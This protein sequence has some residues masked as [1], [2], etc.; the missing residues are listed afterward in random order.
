MKNDPEPAGSPERAGDL[1]KPVARKTACNRP[2]CY[3]LF[4]PRSSQQKYC[5]PE[6]AQAMETVLAREKRYRDQVK[7]NRL[8]RSARP[9]TGP[10]DRQGE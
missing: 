5:S 3:E 10:A 2:G 1:K 9:E 4:T 6:C 8:K 7:A